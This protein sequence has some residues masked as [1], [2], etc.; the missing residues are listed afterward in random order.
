MRR[1]G[2][3]LGYALFLAACVIATDYLFFWRPFVADLRGAERSDLTPPRWVDRATMLRLGSLLVNHTSAFTRAE[4]AK[5]EGML[6]LCA[7]GDSFT[8][9]DEVADGDDYPALLRQIFAEHGAQNV[10]VLNF[11][12]PWH[13]FH[14]A[15]VL[16]DRVGRGFGCDVVLLGPSCFQSERDMTFN[17]TNLRFPYYLHARYV[18]DGNDVRLAKVIG[19]DAAERFDGFFAFVPHLAY[20]RYERNAPAFLQ[21]IVGRQRILKNPFYYDSRPRREEAAATYAILLGHMADTG[22]PIVLLHLQEEIVAIANGLQRANLVGVPVPSD[23]RFP[24]RA[25]AGHFSRFGNRWIADQFYALLTG[26]ASRPTV[27][28]TVPLPLPQSLRADHPAPIAAFER[29]EATLTGRPIGVLAV[30]QNVSEEVEPPDWALRHGTTSLLA[31]VPRGGAFVEAAFVPVPGILHG[32]EPVTMVIAKDGRE[33]RI[34]L[35]SVSIPDARVSLGAVEVAGLEV[36]QEIQLQGSASLSEDRLRDHRVAVFVGDVE[37]LRSERKAWPLVLQALNGDA[38]SVRAHALS[39]G[40]SV[41]PPD[42]GVLVL[43]FARAGETIEI[44]IA[45]WRREAGEGIAASRRL[46]QRVTIANGRADVVA[47]EPGGSR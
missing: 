9:G 20:L 36:A 21:A 26:D 7:F 13:G 8:Y 28:T 47:L 17:H 24:L 40:P 37:V 34:D 30:L 25:P 19:T 1:L 43:V 10:E 35:G 44:P 3:W 41:A 5:P 33:E 16:W 38:R 27:F 12:S 15:Y 2:S 31:F 39:V 6:R 14:Q 23:R 29:I 45:A 46:P 11:G 18:I 22:V 32:G 4:R 42:D